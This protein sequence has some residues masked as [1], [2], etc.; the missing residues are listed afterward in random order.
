M[1]SSLL[2][3]LPLPADEVHI[4]SFVLNPA[5]P[6]QDY[7][8]PLEKDP[9]LKTS[10]L[11]TDVTDFTNTIRDAGSKEVKAVLTDYFSTT[12]DWGKS[13]TLELSS[14]KAATYLMKN[15][16]SWF[17]QVCAL[18]ALRVWFENI[19]RRGYKIYLLVGLRTIFDGRFRIDH[20]ASTS[21]G[22]HAQV[23]ADILAGLPPM[24]LDVGGGGKV[25]KDQTA[26]SEFSAAG[27]RIWALQYRQIKFKWYS[28]KKMENAALETGT[29]WVAML[30]IMSSALCSHRESLTGDASPS[31]RI[32]DLVEAIID[33]ELDLEDQF[34]VQKR[35]GEA[36]FIPNKLKSREKRSFPGSKMGIDDLQSIM[37][38]D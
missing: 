33:D 37:A 19:M 22:G 34:E 12:I 25:L 32:E 23:P 36:L 16:G 14:T 1:P 15:S 29:R 35:S 3:P 18:H 9:D 4:G 30:P 2:L 5:D 13:K 20:S 10:I 7:F 27:E 26:S 28:S 17:E 11:R 24:G 31:N 8:N 21:T 38:R 6:T